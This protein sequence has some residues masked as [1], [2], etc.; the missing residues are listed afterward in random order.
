MCWRREGDRGSDSRHT[1]AS[2]TLS[3]PCGEGGITALASQTRKPRLGAPGE[4]A[5][6]PECNSSPGPAGSEP[7]FLPLPRPRLLPGTTTFPSFPGPQAVS[8]FIL[9]TSTHRII[10]GSGRII[11]T[12][13]GKR[14]GSL[15]SG[16]ERSTL[17]QV[18]PAATGGLELGPQELEGHSVA[19]SQSSGWVA[20]A[21]PAQ[22]PPSPLPAFPCRVP[23]CS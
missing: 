14:A 18:V 16:E 1:V 22:T 12:R 23:S 6:V 19:Q 8:G 13:A 10:N 3:Q 20:A 2:T 4:L 21:F 17:G 5:W 11:T 7:V 15:E 9:A